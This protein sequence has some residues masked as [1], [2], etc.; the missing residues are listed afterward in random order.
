MIIKSQNGAGELTFVDNGMTFELWRGDERLFKGSWWGG[1]RGRPVSVI[2]ADGGKMLRVG[3]EVLVKNPADEVV[4]RRKTSKDI[5]YLRR[6]RG[7]T[8]AEA[9]CWAMTLAA[10]PINIGRKLIGFI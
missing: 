2:E 3:D 6:H 8:E 5:S 10:V 1:R 9:L 7:G 4:V